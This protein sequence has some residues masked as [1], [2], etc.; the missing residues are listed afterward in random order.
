MFIRGARSWAA[1]NPPEAGSGEGAARAQQSADEAHLLL[2]VRRIQAGE[3]SAFEQLYEA[4]REDAARTLRHLVGNR[5][6]VEDLL[7][8]TYLRLLTAVKG[9]R[10]ESRFRTFLYRVCS[11]VALSHL[12]WKRRRPEDSFAE[13]PEVVAPGED[14][15][16]AAERRQ[17]ARLVEAALEKLKPKKRIVFVYHE[18]CG[19][20]PDEIALAVGSSVNTVRS[21]LHHARVEFT[22]AMQRLVVA[23]PM[24]GSHGR[25]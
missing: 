14:P 8:E 24:G 9:F 11:N 13:P 3:L 16:R 10:G 19:M 15:E 20:S 4:T 25:P 2:L 12:R 6:E 7:Q 1:A 18:L 23:R 5:V 21:R 22:E 17:A